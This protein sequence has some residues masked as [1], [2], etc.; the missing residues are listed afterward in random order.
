MSR[1]RLGWHAEAGPLPGA[2]LALAVRATAPLTGRAVARRAAHPLNPW[3]ERTA[4]PCGAVR[5]CA[6]Q[7]RVLHSVP[8]T[9]IT[10]ADGTV[11]EHGQ[12]LDH[13]PRREGESFSR[14]SLAEDKLRRVRQKLAAA[15]DGWIEIC[16]ALLEESKR[17][18]S[19]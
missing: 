1:D 7:N 17:N 19:V 15:R 3:R 6:R 2:G 10:I 8:V 13:L 5:F 12:A 16:V 11:T 4:H 18:D 9:L 14:I